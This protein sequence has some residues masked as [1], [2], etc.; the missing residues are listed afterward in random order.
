[1]ANAAATQTCSAWENHS[2]SLLIREM[3]SFLHVKHNLICAFIAER[4]LHRIQTQPM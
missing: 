3:R 4:D 1:M 2:I